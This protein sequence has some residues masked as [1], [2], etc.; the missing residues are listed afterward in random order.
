[1]N[2]L[3]LENISIKSSINHNN[4]NNSKLHKYFNDSIIKLNCNDFIVNEIDI[5]GFYLFIH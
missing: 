4:N 1:M 2:K 5:N 3:H